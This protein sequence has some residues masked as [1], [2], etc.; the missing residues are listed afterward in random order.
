[1]NNQ[2]ITIL[3]TTL[4]D[5]EQRE[6]ISFTVKDK[7]RIT[8]LLDKLGIH[9]VEGGWPGSN[10]KALAYFKA[11]KNLKLKNTKIAA[12]SSTR[13][14]KSK[15]EDDATLQALLAAET[16]V[17]VIFGKAWDFHVQSALK[18][19]LDENLALIYD[20]LA[21]MKKHQKEVIFDLE[22]FFDGYKHNPKYAME[23]I[24]AANEA[25]SDILCF[26]D[27]NGGT[28]AHEI[29]QIVARVKKEFPNTNFGIHA[30]NDNGLAVANS[31]AAV[32]EGVNHLQGTLNGYGER[33]GN[34]NL[35]TI[36]PTLVLKLGINC[37]TLEQL[38][39]LTSTCFHLDEIANVNHDAYMPYVGRS[40]FTHK[41]G[42]HVNAV[43]KNPNTY[44]HIEPEK[45]GNQR[46]VVVSELSGISNLVYK[47]KEFGIVIDETHTEKLKALTLKIKELEHMGY[48]YEE[49]DVSLFMLMLKSLTDFTPKIDLQFFRVISERNATK[50]INIEAT[51]KAK[52]NKT[53]LIIAA[54]GNG[55]VSALDKA[56]HKAL[57]PIYPQIKDIRLTDYKV[58][59]LD[60]K[61]GTDSQVR[62]HIEWEDHEEEWGTVGVS[63][64]IIDASWG[65]L[66]D[67]YEYKLLKGKK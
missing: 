65:A 44:E 34:M 16:P 7:L 61:S 37:V 38:N 13:R 29:T 9:Y 49:A 32:L 66:V 64:N 42:V 35:S 21:Y 26:C 15:P 58:R 8:E 14:A 56:L 31:L 54:E 1:M 57:L 5:G 11:V 52:I 17:V 18:I 12:F 19:S 20:S 40:A 60:S 33:A 43:L 53:K 47:A 48:Q 25:K 41:A 51:L 22:H 24:K 55:P 62:V 28:L 59:V 63:Q 4:R 10:P 36:I 67:S 6:G 45:V 46:R 30:H 3:D 50:D 27:T 2:N 39:T 23:V